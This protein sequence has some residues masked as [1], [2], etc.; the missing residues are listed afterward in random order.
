M[1]VLF[2]GGA[3]IFALTT[4]ALKA[5]GGPSGLP[6]EHPMNALAIQVAFVAP[7]CLLPALVLGGLGF[8]WFFPAA[9]VAVGAHYLP[10]VFL[11]GMRLFGLLAAAMC[12]GAVALAYLPAAPASAG[13]WFGGVLLVVFAFLLRYVELPRLAA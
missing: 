2:V 6:R 12:V 5:T 1:A 8:R 9:L 7:L 13:G 3:T 10:F 4:L 11:Y